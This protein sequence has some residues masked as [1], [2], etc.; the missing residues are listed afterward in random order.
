MDLGE[1]RHFT[2][3]SG[4]L[5]VADGLDRAHV[6]SVTHLDVA[7]LDNYLVITV[8]AG[9][10]DAD[11]AGATLKRGLLERAASMVVLIRAAQ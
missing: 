5:R 4:I 7:N 2:W 1:Q 3:V 8:A 9:V 6:G 10:T 11:L